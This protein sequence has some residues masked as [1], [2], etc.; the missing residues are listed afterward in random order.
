MAKAKT[1]IVK[2][3]DYDL[4]E[5]RAGEIQAS[6]EPMIVERKLL[7]KEYEAIK[8][9]EV[10]T[11]VCE[12]AGRLR[13]DLVKVRTGIDSV[14]RTQKHMFLMAGRFVDA[15]KNAET[16]P[17]RQ[18]EEKLR[19]IEK[20]FENLE[21]LRINKIRVARVEELRK[22][23]VVD[24]LCPA[25]L[26]EMEDSVWENYLSGV[27]ASYNQRKEAEAKAEE[28]RIAQEKADAEESERLRLENEKL[29]K[30]AEGRAKK[31]EKERKVREAK[32]A[33]IQAKLKADRDAVAAE[34][35]TEREER[36]RA[37]KAR[38]AKEA[39]EAKAREAANAKVEADL[40][41]EREERERLERENAEREATEREEREETEAREKD[42]AHRK[43]VNNAI[44]DKMI[45]INDSW[46][47]TLC[48]KIVKAMVKGEIPNVSVN[49]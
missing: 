28:E 12:R 8:K 24:E 31:E 30:E 45:E 9:L 43:A 36:E 29:K 48:T 39:K 1:A 25:G 17:V 16:L 10:D 33:K 11:D 38:A 49:Y 20:H 21:L 26:G 15:W 3:S 22:Y 23:G 14:H 46:P 7:A 2:A 18:M 32:E 41:A 27:K 40:Q 13:K 37:D 44:I 34:L 42:T 6:F 19:D 5:K 47:R 4:D 35:K